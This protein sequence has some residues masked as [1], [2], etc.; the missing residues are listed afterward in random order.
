MDGRLRSYVSQS[1][2]PGFISAD[3]LDQA[4]IKQRTQQIHRALTGYT[5]RRPYFTGGHAPVVAEQME[6]L[7]LTRAQNQF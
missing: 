6:K 7:F 2:S 4:G 3:F 1:V 5:K